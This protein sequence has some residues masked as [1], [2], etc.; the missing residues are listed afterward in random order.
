MKINLFKAIP[1]FA[2]GLA[3]V[4]CTSEAYQYTPAEKEDASKTVV[5]ADMNAS[6]NLDVD[7][8]PVQIPFV[9][10]NASGSLSINV[11]LDDPSGL[12]TLDNQTVTF[13]D[14][15]DTAYASVSYSYDAL[16]ANGEY[17]FSVG[18]SSTENLSEYRAAA[19]PVTC[20]K[21]WQK[22]GIA[23]FYDDWWVGGPFEKELIK[24]PDGTETYRL[25]NPW[26]E[27]E[28]VDGGLEFVSQL[29]YLEF[30]VDENGTITYANRLN[31]GFTFGG[32]T[33]H[34]LHPSQRNDAASAAE[35]KMVMEDV[36]QFVWYPILNYNNGSFSWWGVTSVAYI[37]FP[38]GP[39]LAELLG[40]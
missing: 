39:D 11:Y 33:C 14:G 2:L 9:R 30:F 21:A 40:L 15:E 12:F 23:Q 19:F 3:L 18:I 20:K 29:P 8:T 17:S 28:V 4:A 35:N 13:A 5:G 26:T 38:G 7:G 10:N 25:L 34:M 31:M 6:R 16:D 22:L 32:R 36:A 1:A 24:A 37:S 27:E